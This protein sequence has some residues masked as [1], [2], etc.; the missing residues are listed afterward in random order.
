MKILFGQFLAERLDWFGYGVSSANRTAAFIACAI[1]ASWIFVGV[2]KRAGYWLSLFASL[3]LFYFLLLTQSRGALVALVFSM[4][5]FFAFSRVRYGRARIISFC[6]AGLLACAA[7]FNSNVSDRVYNM[8]SLK[9]SSANCR[10]E[11]YLSG[12]KMLSDAP[13]GLKNSPVET[14]MRWY[15]NTDDGN[16]YLSM[17]NSHLE[18]MC[19]HG[20]F[21]AAFYVFLWCF[22]LTA[23][24]P[25]DKN[26]I[27]AAAF[28][29]WMCYGICASFS[30]V[31]NYWVLWIIPFFML[32]AGMSANYRNIFTKRFTFVFLIS[33]FAVLAFVYLVSLSAAMGGGLDFIKNGD[34]YCGNKSNVKYALYAPSE[35]VLGVHF[36]GELLKFCKEKDVGAFVSDRVKNI[37]ELECALFCGDIGFEQVESAKAKRKVLLNPKVSDGFDKMQSNVYVYLGAFSDWRNR[38]E[39]ERIAS[40]NGNV[41]VKILDGVSDFIPNWTGCF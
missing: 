35:Q 27:S 29:A 24:F 23:L 10:A 31:M 36:G 14:Y 8:A 7:F 12:I 19:K 21:A 13:S 25:H 22:V 16:F 4:A 11:I 9:S 26:P 17:I 38:R 34:V 28:A 2:F 40:C 33:G 1:V 30:N 5:F 3:I 15:Q 41:K 20:F 6:A 37:G 32:V 18:F 39:W